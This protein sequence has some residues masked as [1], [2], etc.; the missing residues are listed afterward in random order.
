MKRAWY[1]WPHVTE[2]WIYKR[3]RGEKP[4]LQ[5]HKIIQFR[6][7][8]NIRSNNSSKNHL[9]PRW[10]KPL[11]FALFL[12]AFDEAGFLTSRFRQAY[13][14]TILQRLWLSTCV[15]SCTQHCPL[16]QAITA[17]VRTL[18]QKTRLP[19]MSHKHLSLHVCNSLLGVQ[20][21]MHHGWK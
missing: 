18:K 7:Y 10:D 13:A 1:P 14:Q 15:E 20:K 3:N 12:A 6:V 9:L 17:F 4:S 8:L 21:N 19:I 16:P 11:D 2:H 5:L